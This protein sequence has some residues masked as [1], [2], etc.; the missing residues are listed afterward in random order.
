MN[1]GDKVFVY[2][3]NLKAEWHLANDLQPEVGLVTM[4]ND[5]G[6]VNVAGFTH[7]ARSFSL[8]SVPVQTNYDPANE[9]AFVTQSPVATS[10]A[11]A[12]ANAQAAAKAKADAAQAA[13]LAAAEAK[14]QADAKALVDAKAAADAKAA[15][16]AKAYAEARVAS[17]NAAKASQPAGALAGGQ[18]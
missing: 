18:P 6:T 7:D 4:L 2:R 11:I 10:A 12:L 13:T 3:P 5:D 17:E 15:L 9:G 8:I 1:I 14:A 16:E